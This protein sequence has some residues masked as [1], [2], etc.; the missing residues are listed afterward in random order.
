MGVADPR[1][2]QAEASEFHPESRLLCGLETWTF[3]ACCFHMDR[4]GLLYC[5]VELE[6]HPGCDSWSDS[7]DDL[8]P[9]SCC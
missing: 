4:P 9:T 7:S 5:G 1:A 6:K 8:T 2:L 3:W